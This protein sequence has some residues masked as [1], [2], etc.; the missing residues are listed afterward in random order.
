MG[1]MTYGRIGDSG[2]VA[3]TV[4]LGCNA[5]GARIDR[6]RTFAVLSA[7]LDAGITFF[8]TADI[9][10]QGASEELVGEGLRAHRDE[11]VLATKFG[12]EMHGT[13]GPDF[14]A[15]GSRRYV[16]AAVEAS[17][18]RL[19]TDRIDLYQMHEPDPV[20]PI[21]E[22]LDTLGDLVREGKVRYVGASQFAAWEL[23]DAV[24]TS[25]TRGGPRMISTQENYNLLERDVELELA[26][27][28]ERF[29][30]GLI[31]Y[32]PLG[33]GLLTG[34]YERGRPAPEGTKLAQR[35]AVLAG[36]DFDRID[37]LRT[38]AEERGVSLLTV[39]IAGLAAQPA[40]ATVIAGAT[41]PEQ[42]TANAAAVEWEPTPVDLAV[43]DEIAPAPPPLPG[44]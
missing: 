26:P 19:G 42:V 10:G 18:R 32:F 3:S 20:T 28:C 8:D 36:A 40:V 30:V 6:D 41:K 16:R 21:E 15:R 34:K 43:L 14:G 17:L 27:A 22:T 1:D 9:Y 39:A 25:R 2:L 5:F 31:P 13:N 11:I 37:T 23:A 44:R 38:F 29:G 33:N 4:G 12:K 35:P 24:W 7:A